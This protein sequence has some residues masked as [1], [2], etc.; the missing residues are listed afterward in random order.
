MCKCCVKKHT[1]DFWCSALVAFMY[2]KMGWF[3][4]DLDW[5]DQ[6]PTDL[7]TIS[8]QQPYELGDMWRLK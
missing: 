8:A 1:N 3:D 5:S 7:T 6:S 4:E 2:V